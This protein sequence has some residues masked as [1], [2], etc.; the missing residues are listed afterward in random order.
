MTHATPT[1][2]LLTLVIVYHICY[3]HV[4][5]PSIG[6]RSLTYTEY[7]KYTLE[8]YVHQIPHVHERNLHARYA[9]MTASQTTITK[10]SKIDYIHDCCSVGL[11][12]QL[13]LVISQTNNTP[14]N[15]RHIV[16]S[17]YFE[18]PLHSTLK[19]HYSN[20]LKY[21]YCTV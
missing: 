14:R 1:T 11:T 6:A 13:S 20:T 2:S 17:Y 3:P 19:Y 16:V 8:T 18:L 4:T 10:S 7:F 9:V 12:S 5:F 21:C 15:L